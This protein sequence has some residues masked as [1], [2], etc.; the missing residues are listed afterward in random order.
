MLQANELIDT[1]HRFLLENTHF[2][3]FLY[4]KKMQKYFQIPIPVMPC[5]KKNWF[6]NFDLT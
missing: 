6:T 3:R 2:L 5:S 4:L 1:F